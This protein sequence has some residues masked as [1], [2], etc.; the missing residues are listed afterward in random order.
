MLK[1]A[2]KLW[3]HRNLQKEVF[4][5]YKV[6]TF[7][8]KKV[9]DSQMKI[10]EKVAPTRVKRFVDFKLAKVKTVEPNQVGRTW[11]QIKAEPLNGGKVS[12]LKKVMGA[13]NRSTMQSYLDLRLIQIKGVRP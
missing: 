6:A 1:S 8:Q 13:L 7:N 5:F 9:V 11:K 4:D 2:K 12:G 3:N 10:I